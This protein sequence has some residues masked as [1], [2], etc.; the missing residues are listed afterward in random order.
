MNTIKIYNIILLVV[1]VVISFISPLSY[2]LWLHRLEG[3]ETLMDNGLKLDETKK[4]TALSSKTRNAVYFQ[5]L[6]TG[7]IDAMLMFLPRLPNNS[8]STNDEENLMIQAMLDKN[9]IIK[10]KLNSDILSVLNNN[11]CNYD[12]LTSDL[13]FRAVSTRISHFFETSDRN[14]RVK[15]YTLIHREGKQYGFVVL[16][17]SLWKSDMTLIGYTDAIVVGT[18]AEDIINLEHGYLSKFKGD[19]TIMKSSAYEKD[20]IERQAN[21]IHDD[22]GISALGF[23]Q[24]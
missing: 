4:S 3:F 7:D 13:K 2:M 14:I 15:S 8:C 11:L 6:S 19:E 1:L 18:I 22:R 10:T 21:N 12:K 9:K 16:T 20:L 23:L 5:E 17:V 24:S